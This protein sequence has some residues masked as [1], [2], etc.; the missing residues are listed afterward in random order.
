MQW[1]PLLKSH[2]IYNKFLYS[3]LSLGPYFFQQLT[4]TLITAFSPPVTLKILHILNSSVMC[5]QVTWNVFLINYSSF[6]M[7]HN[8]IFSEV[9]LIYSLFLLLRLNNT[10]IISLFKHVLIF[11]MVTSY[12]CISIAGLYLAPCLAHFQ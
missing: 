10:L 2:V 12:M 7:Q 5:Y 11:T 6:K 8:F 4:F 9:I 1:V 3:H